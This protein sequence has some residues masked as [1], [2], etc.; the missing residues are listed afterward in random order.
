VSLGITLDLALLTFFGFAVELASTF[1][2]ALVEA[3]ALVVDLAGVLA[4]VVIGAFFTNYQR[5]ITSYILAKNVP[6]IN[7]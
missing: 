4:G 1:A 5:L 3:F 6:P 7:V 2:V